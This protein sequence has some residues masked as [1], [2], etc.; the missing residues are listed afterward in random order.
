[1]NESQEK[2]L[3]DLNNSY[4]VSHWQVKGTSVIVT[5]DDRDQVEITEHGDK[6]WKSA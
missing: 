6:I 1:M 3:A 4:G 2:T 5:L